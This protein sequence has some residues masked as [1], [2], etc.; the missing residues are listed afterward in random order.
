MPV[1]FTWNGGKLKSNLDS[2]E[3]K[4]TA[5]LSKTTVYY[6]L[7]AET[8]AKKNAKWKDRSGNARSGLTSRYEVG[9]GSGATASYS[10]ELSH[11]VNYGIFLETRVFSRKGDLSIVKPTLDYIAPR[12]QKTAGDVLQR[13]YG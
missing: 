11:S 12:F 6:S 2:S 3:R 10:I 7:M 5:Y 1:K 8:R 4:A 9:V 13:I